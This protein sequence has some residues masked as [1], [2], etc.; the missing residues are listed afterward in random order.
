[1]GKDDVI[2]CL[3]LDWVEHWV[4]RPIVIFI[5][6]FLLIYWKCEEEN[7]EAGNG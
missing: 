1:M 7:G 6:A 3:G 4:E 5:F 2:V